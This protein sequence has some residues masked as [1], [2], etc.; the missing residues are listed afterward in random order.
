MK[1]R[2]KKCE[3]TMWNTYVEYC[4]AYLL[5]ARKKNEW[6]KESLD[7]GPKFQNILFRVTVNVLLCSN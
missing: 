1:N 3:I 5:H 2:E 4:C 7:E 6:K